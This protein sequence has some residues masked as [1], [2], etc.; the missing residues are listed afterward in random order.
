MIRKVRC[1]PYIKRRAEAESP[2]SL[3]DLARAY[4]WPSGLEG[5]GRLALVELGGGW[6]DSDMQRFFGS[7]GQPVPHI[8][9]VSVDGTENSKQRPR[10][11]ADVEVALDLQVM[12]SAYFLATG[13]EAIIRIYWAQ[14]ISS[15][16]QSAARDGCSVCSISWGADEQNWGR[17]AGLHLDSVA[18]AANTFGTTVFAAAGDNDSSDGGPTP[19]NVDLPASSP[20]VIACGGTTKTKTSEIVWNDNP[21]ESDGE[22]TGGGYSTLFPV[23]AWQKIPT[24]RHGLGRMVPDLA[25]NADPNTGYRIVCYGEDQVVGGTSAV[26]PLMAGL[27]GALGKKFSMLPKELW[28]IPSG[29]TDITKGSNGLYS[30]SVGPDPC[31]G[32]GSPIAAKLLSLL[33]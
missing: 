25:A 17:E 15:A 2:W 5:G 21:G 26:A 3:P 23:P 18:A 4:D 16:I 1:R 31:S 28:A 20:H 33:K 14:D 11:D 8:T 12:G 24:P 9:D 32:L 7:I 30:A 22:G 27:F 13:K 29:F 19:A 10:T 6:L